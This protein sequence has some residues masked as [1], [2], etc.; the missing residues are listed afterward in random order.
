M[1]GIGACAHRVL[2]VPRIARK[3]SNLRRAGHGNKRELLTWHCSLERGAVN[4]GVGKDSGE[5][6]KWAKGIILGTNLMRWVNSHNRLLQ[7]L[8]EHPTEFREP[9]DR[10]NNK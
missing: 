7:L 4:G 1:A 8:G 10:G 9:S 5:V 2:G 6:K 3:P